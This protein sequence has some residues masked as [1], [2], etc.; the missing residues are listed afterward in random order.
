MLTAIYARYSSDR[1]RE[2]SLADQEAVCRRRAESEGLR[3]VEVYADAAISGSR[4][5]RPHYQRLLEDAGSGRWQALLIEDLSRLS[6]DEIEGNQAVRRLEYRGIRVIGVSDGYDSERPGRTAQRSVRALL[7]ALYFEDLAA[8]THRGQEG[9][10]ARGYRAGG[11]PYGYRPVRT[12]T[13]SKLEIDPEQAEIVREIWTRFADGESP[14]NITADLNARAV[15]S[16]RTSNRKGKASWV[17]SALYGHPAKGTGILRNPIYLG[18]QIWN[19]SKW[20]KDPDTGRRTRRER[21]QTE[22]QVQ[23]IPQ[24][25]IISPELEQRVARRH[26][27]I[28]ESSQRAR[29]TMKNN[30]ST[31]PRPRYL[32]SGLMNCAHCG[33]PV[34]SV[35]GHPGRYGC[36]AARYRGDAICS[37]RTTIVRHKL[38]SRILAAVRRDLYS[39]EAISAYRTALIAEIK[40]AAQETAPDING[41]ERQVLEIEQRIDNMV[42]AIAAGSFSPT[43]QRALETAEAERASITRQLQR[44]TAQQAIVPM[45]TDIEEALKRQLD[46]LDATLAEDINSARE[47]LRDLLGE[48]RIR[49]SD[50]GRMVAEVQGLGALHYASDGSGGRI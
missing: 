1:Q 25:R 10:V 48:V 14:R 26:A 30:G 41:L 3:I 27:L 21:P 8:R 44:A 9:Q 17:S 2:T 12:D 29:E 7:S 19:R 47:I 4:Q 37:Q 36:S 16:P 15:P 31:G 35:G 22:W 40:A 43:L 50:Q 11:L 38:E 46:A 23:E 39:P 24:L 33:A 18:R 5:D 32:L 28:A 34:V 13:G 20:I 49:Q 42:S 6:R 45:P